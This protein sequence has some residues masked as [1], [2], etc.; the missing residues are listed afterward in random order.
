MRL[1]QEHDPPAR[2]IQA[3]IELIE[4]DGLPALTVRAVAAAARVNIAAVN[5]YFR[6]K[7]AL[8][9][10]ALDASI[11]HMVDDSEP[12]I[13][14][15]KADA[16]GALGELLRYYVEGGFAYPHLGKAH[17][18]DAF[19]ADE[20]GGAFPTLFAPVMERLRDAIQRAVPGL[21][22]RAASRRAVAALSG[23]LFPPFFAGFFR[24]LGALASEADRAAYAGELARAALT[25]LTK[26]RR[27]R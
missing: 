17:L 4:K 18:H 3:A 22:K 7:D 23:A 21:D 11:R 13:A 19:V 6:S 16:E 25:P 8:V 24:P 5:Y 20:Y 14:R 9:A 1:E 26:A 15:M 2:L 10:A 12:L 27:T